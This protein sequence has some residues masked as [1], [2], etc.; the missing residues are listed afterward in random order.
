MA[1]LLFRLGAGAFRHRIAVTLVWL[2]VLV[3]GVTTVVGL[4]LTDSLVALFDPGDEVADA[5]S[6]YLSWAWL[7]LTPMLLV[8]AATGVLRGLADTRTPLAVAVAA[9][10]SL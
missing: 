8:L 5:A 3:G 4:L 10:G 7:G 6:A 9:V 1:R 2:A